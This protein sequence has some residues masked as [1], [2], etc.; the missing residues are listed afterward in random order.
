M[1]NSYVQGFNLV[2][3]LGQSYLKASPTPRVTDTKTREGLNTPFKHNNYLWLRATS[4]AGIL[5]GLKARGKSQAIAPRRVDVSQAAATLAV[6]LYGLSVLFFSWIARPRLIYFFL[7]TKKH[8]NITC[9][10]KSTRKSP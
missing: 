8:D 2:E 5:P 7:R 9:E 4:T 3:L 6:V 1:N 10:K